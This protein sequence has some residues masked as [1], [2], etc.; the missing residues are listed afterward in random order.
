MEAYKDKT[1][2]SYTAKLKCASLHDFG[3]WQDS[4]KI[5]TPTGR[6]MLSCQP[7]SPDTTKNVDSKRDYL[8]SLVSMPKP[9][10]CQVSGHTLLISQAYQQILNA[11]REYARPFSYD[12]LIPIIKRRLDGCPKTP[13][14]E[15]YVRTLAAHKLLFKVKEGVYIYNAGADCGQVDL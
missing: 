8:P 9:N 11:A 4:T 3:N 13:T 2:I 1:M 14:L 7:K 12:D 5:I 10:G 15:R 6:D